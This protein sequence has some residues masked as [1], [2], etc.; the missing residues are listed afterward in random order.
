MSFFSFFFCALISI[1]LLSFYYWHC[2]RSKSR[3][4]KNA[5]PFSLATMIH[6]SE[7]TFTT[8]N[9]P[10]HSFQVTLEPSSFTQEKFALYCKYQA[11]IH[12]D[13]DKSPSGFKQFLVDSPLTVRL[14]ML[15]PTRA[16][17]KS[18]LQREKIKYPTPPPAHLP[19]EYGAYHQVPCTLLRVPDRLVDERC[20]LAVQI[21]WRT[22]CRGRYRRSP[23][24]RI[25]RVLYVQQDIRAFLPRKGTCLSSLPLLLFLNILLI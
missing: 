4:S 17:A 2:C 24:L 1:N 15:F 22:H 6:A 11:E 18:V 5:A 13:E 25:E 14:C 16:A 12:H 10:A 3:K 23:Y 21:G 9:Q 8:Y 19:T 7:Q 20:M